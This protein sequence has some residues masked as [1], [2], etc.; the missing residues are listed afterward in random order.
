MHRIYIIQ[1]IYNINHV[2]EKECR[3]AG[4]TENTFLNCYSIDYTYKAYIVDIVN[5]S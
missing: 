2:Y 5:Q 3:T 1:N 4:L